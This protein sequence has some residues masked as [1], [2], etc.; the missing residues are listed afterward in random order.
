MKQ[1]MKILIRLFISLTFLF[2]SCNNANKTN[3]DNSNR[4]EIK[5]TTSKTE[6]QEITVQ[7][8]IMDSVNNFT[9]GDCFIFKKEKFN[10]GFILT[11]MTKGSGVVYN[12]TPV[13]LDATKKGINKFMYGSIRMVP[14]ATMTG[15]VENWGTEC[16]SLMG[17]EDVKDFLNSFT[18]V[19]Q[20]KFK[21]N[22]P[23]VSSSNYLTEYTLNE[24][25]KFFKEQEM[26]WIDQ[27]KTED[28]NKLVEME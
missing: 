27:N 22:A 13:K 24:L 8:L 7:E 18:K 25:N 9:I 3:I 21:G 14:I 20:V 12:F 17:Q 4:Q 26:M 1:Y 15:I 2:T 28:L 16:L 11:K 19:G 5:Q 10:K 23:K 6:K